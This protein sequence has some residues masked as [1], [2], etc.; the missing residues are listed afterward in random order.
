MRNNSLKICY[1]DE[2]FNQETWVYGEVVNYNNS[3]VFLMCEDKFV[4]IPH[5]AIVWMLP[6]G[7]TTQKKE[8]MKQKALNEAVEKIKETVDNVYSI[9]GQ[10]PS[11]VATK[12][13]IETL[14]KKSGID[15]Q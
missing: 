7:L 10:K 6:N 5:K 12:E 14:S 8:K 1:K 3:G 9:T 2:K 4:V 15:I 11:I 13:I